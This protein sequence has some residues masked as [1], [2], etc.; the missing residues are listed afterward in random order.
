MKKRKLKPFVKGSIVG[1]LLLV[2]ALGVGLLL[3]NQTAS[4][5]KVDSNFIYVTI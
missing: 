2:C 3:N 4:V 1:T 5:S